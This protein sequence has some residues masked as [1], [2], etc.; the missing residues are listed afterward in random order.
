MKISNTPIF[1]L[2]CLAV[3]FSSTFAA[4][5]QTATPTPKI[6]DDE[7]IKVDSRLIVVPVSVTNANGDPILGLSAADFRVTEEGRSQQIDTVSGADKVPLEIALLFDVS[8]ST[9]KMFK[10]ELE[11]A[12]K[13]LRDVMRAGD[14]ATIFSIGAKPILVQPRDTADRTAA[15]I[16]TITPTKEF[17]AFYDTVAAA[18]DYLKMNAPEGSRKV[19]LVISDGEDTH[20]VSITKAINDGYRKIN[21]NKIDSKALYELTVKNRNEAGVAE[22]KRILKLLQDVDTVF[23]SI[24]PAGS[25]LQLNKMSLAGQEVMQKFAAD[26]GGTAFLPKFQPFDTKDDLQNTANSRKNAEILD[27]IFRQLG[28]EL[29]SQYLVQ[30]YSD[31]DFPAGRFVNLG[32]GLSNRTDLKIRARQ[33]YFVT[34]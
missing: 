29:R 15:V 28:N 10:Y 27:R 2:L 1:S 24:N 13:F 30:Y 18:A 32:V 23:Y 25:S 4:F 17:T 8:A 21:I 19:L 16:N 7:I 33:G 22:R 11:T 12:A 9:D 3:V 14:R 26:T 31:A 34:N 5:G 20:S 6:T